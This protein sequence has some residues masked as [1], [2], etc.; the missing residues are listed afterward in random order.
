MAPHLQRRPAIQPAESFAAKEDEEHL[1]VPIDHLNE[2][3]GAQWNE[4]DK[5]CEDDFVQK[6]RTNSVGDLRAV[7]GNV[8]M[9]ALPAILSDSQDMRE[10]FDANPDAYT[11][12]M[13]ND[14]LPI[15][16]RRCN[17]H[18]G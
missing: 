2:A 12:I 17:D 13:N 4:A 9:R 3:F 1:S 5:I 14:L 18:E 11:R 16:Y 6:A 7:F 15:V 8:M 10:Q